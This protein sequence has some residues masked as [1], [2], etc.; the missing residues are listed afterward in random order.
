MYV[1]MY[2]LYNVAEQKLWPNKDGAER[3]REKAKKRG[4]SLLYT[5][6]IAL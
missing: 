4:N 6:N 5:H 3:E 1:C 2:T